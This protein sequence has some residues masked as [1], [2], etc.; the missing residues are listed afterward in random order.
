MFIP[1]SFIIVNCLFFDNGEHIALA[2]HQIFL[3]FKLKFGTAIFAIKHFVAGFQNHLFVLSALSSSNNFTVE[4]FLFSCIRNDNSTNLFFCGRG[5]Y[6]HA[7][8]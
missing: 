8:T 4:R 2:H 1:Y 3:T 7:V 5:Q 6:Q